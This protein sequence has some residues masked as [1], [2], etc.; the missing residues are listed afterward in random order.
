MKVISKKTVKSSTALAQVLAERRVL[1]RTLDSPF[2]VG[3]KFSFQSTTEL[4]F[5]IDY[6]S[7]GE[8][9]MHLE[10]NGGRFEE[11]KVRFYLCEIILALEYLHSQNII[12][13][14]LKPEK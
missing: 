1:A 6:K 10:R 9:F 13:R 12:Y 2:L 5:V 4:F 14:D 8:L 3:L 7:G 11:E